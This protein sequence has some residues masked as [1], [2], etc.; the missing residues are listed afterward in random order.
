MGYPMSYR[1]VIDR[2]GLKGSYGY[3]VNENQAIQ[4][5]AMRRWNDAVSGEDHLDRVLWEAVSP[6]RLSVL[7]R[8]PL[9]AYTLKFYREHG[10]TDDETL[11]HVVRSFVNAVQQ[12]A[13]W[14][15]QRL[16]AGDLRRLEQD[17]RDPRHLEIYAKRAGVTPEQAKAVLDAFF[18][19]DL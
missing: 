10:S 15:A 3:L 1:R 8:H 6:D 4:A 18:D 12:Y 7:A 17:Q 19:E 16:V 5:P 13:T 9:A 14:A 11:R 2:N